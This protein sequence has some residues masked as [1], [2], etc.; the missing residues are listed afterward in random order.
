MCCKVLL[1]L[2]I[3]FIVRFGFKRT[4]LYRE[5]WR[6]MEIDGV[7]ACC[8]VTVVHCQRT[9]YAYNGFGEWCGLQYGLLM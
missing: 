3:L 6:R 1:G 4:F 5:R 8:S 7:F 2:A 9:L